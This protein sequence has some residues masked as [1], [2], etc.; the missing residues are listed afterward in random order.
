MMGQQNVAQMDMTNIDPTI[1]MQQLGNM[2]PVVNMGGMAPPPQ[3]QQQQ[4][5][6]TNAGGGY[7]DLKHD[8][9]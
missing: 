2:A 7:E 4:Q 5:M 3:R 8:Q 1:G 6:Q 9:L